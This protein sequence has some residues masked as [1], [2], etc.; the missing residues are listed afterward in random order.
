MSAR[1][2]QQREDEKARSGDPEFGETL[3]TSNSTPVRS[4]ADIC[5]RLPR[6]PTALSSSSVQLVHALLHLT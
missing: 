2:V 5:P 4:H 1:H 3:R 6:G